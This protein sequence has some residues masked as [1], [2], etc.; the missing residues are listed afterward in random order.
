[1]QPSIASLTTQKGFSVGRQ[2]SWTTA[3]IPSPAAMTLKLNDEE[4]VRLFGTFP[5]I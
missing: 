4:I 1:M 3:P 2:K 5:S